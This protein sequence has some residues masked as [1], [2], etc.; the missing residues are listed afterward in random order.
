[1]FLID[2]P[3]FQCSLLMFF[4]TD[5]VSEFILL[6][7]ILADVPMFLI[8]QFFPT[9]QSHKHSSGLPATTANS[10][11]TKAGQCFIINGSLF[12]NCFLFCMMYKCDI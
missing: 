10:M 8:S 4:L 2:L 3:M 1:M 6:M 9:Q 11:T 7:F 12:T 5:S